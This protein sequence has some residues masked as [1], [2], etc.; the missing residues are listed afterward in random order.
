M[1]KVGVTGGIGAGKSTVCRVFETLGIPVFYADDAAKFLMNSDAELRRLIIQAFGE[2]AYQ[3]ESLNNNYLGKL[4]FGNPGKLAQLNALTHPAVIRFGE[5]WM[6]QQSTPYALKEAAVFFES[7][8]N[9]SMDLMIGVS[10][11]LP[12]RI[13][14]AMLRGDLSESQVLERVSKQMDEE[15]KMSLCD[16]RILN[17]DAHSIIEQVW[18]LHQELLQKA[19]SY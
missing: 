19:K 13:R 12:L 16:Y 18:N 6:T 3:N 5:T 1:L 8:S 9:K 15:E 10:A 17:D 14:R 7:G 11:P 2:A 4:V